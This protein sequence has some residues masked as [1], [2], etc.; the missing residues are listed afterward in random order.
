MTEDEQT[1]FIREALRKLIE[2]KPWLVERPQTPPSPGVPG[3]GSRLPRP[4]M[5][6][7]AAWLAL[8]QSGLNR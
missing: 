3:Y 8:L 2:E 4:P 1:L 7:N 6:S 5:S